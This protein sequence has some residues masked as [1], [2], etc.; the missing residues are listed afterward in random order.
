MQVYNEKDLDVFKDSVKDIIDQVKIAQLETFEPT[1]REMNQVMEII[2]NYIKENNRKVY[3]GYA[4]N[5]LLKSKDPNDAIYNDIEFADIDFYSPEPI[6]DLIKICNELA[7]KGFKEPIGKEAQH[8]ETYSIFVNQ[9]LYCDIT[10]VP[11]NVYNRMPFMEIDGF[12][13]I[14]PHFMMIDFFRMFTDPL[15]SYWRLEKVMPRFYKL[16]K[17]YPFLKVKN[18][19]VTTPT[20]ENVY[21]YLINLIKNKKSVIVVGGYAY[22]QFLKESK[23]NRPEIKNPMIEIIS[24]EYEKDGKEIV[25]ALKSEYSKDIR[26]IEYYPFFQ[27][28]THSIVVF[29]K[30]NPIMR[31]QGN[32]K[33]CYPFRKI[34]INDKDF[35]Q[36]GSFDLTLLYSMIQAIIHRTNKEVQE[37]N[38]YQRMISDLIDMRDNYFKV[39]P[40]KTMVDNTLFRSFS[41]ECVGEAIDPI[42]EFRESIGEKKKK[43]SGPLIFKYEPTV[44]RKEPESNF[45]FSNT[46][47]NP[48]NNVKNLKLL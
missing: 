4:L 33:K 19:I 37:M 23:L 6:E 12:K 2:N 14:H 18:D 36:I 38:N 44:S 11:K 31:I 32:N 25:D 20:D 41:V 13:V 5:L 46:S 27:F 45:I 34:D 43:K 21:R 10:Y 7:D 48:I 28:T 39:N 42:R 47:G 24:T 9:F 35:I 16:Q 26:F 1:K 17:H 15:I 22:N 3:G 30:D 8:K 29:Y 40:K